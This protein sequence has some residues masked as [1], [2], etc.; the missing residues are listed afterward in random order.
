MEKFK[1]LLYT[2]STVVNYFTV[3]K[4]FLFKLIYFL[5]LKVFNLFAHITSLFL[6]EQKKP[7]NL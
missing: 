3:K 5:L 4:Q 7:I 1:S 2:S 6:I